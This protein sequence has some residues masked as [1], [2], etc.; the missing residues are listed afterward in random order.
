MFS[1]LSWS[2]TKKP[3]DGQE[4]GDV[5]ATRTEEEGGVVFTAEKCPPAP[6]LDMSCE[7]PFGFIW[8]PMGKQDSNAVIVDGKMPPVL[9]LN[10]LCY[11]NPHA[12]VDAKAGIWICPLCEHENVAP[13]QLLKNCPELTSKVI[14]YH[15]PVP[16]P[17]KGESEDEED[18]DD[19]GDSDE[20]RE[21]DEEGGGILVKGKDDDIEI[22]E[23]TT[24]YL[25]VDSHLNGPDALAIGSTMD[26][27]I[28]ESDRPVRI[29]L[30]VFDH[31]VKI[32]RLGVPG[33]VSADVYEA[34]DDDADESVLLERKKEIED[35]AY[36]VETDAEDGVT[37]SLD[38]CLTAIFGMPG[39]GTSTMKPPTRLEMLKKKREGRL[40]KLANSVWGGKGDAN[41]L[42]QTTPAVESPW[43][44]Q[45]S[46][47]VHPQ[48]CTSD[49][50]QAALDM[51]GVVE[52]SQGTR[53]L[54]FTNGCPNMGEGS[55]VNPQDADENRK[56][57]DVIDPDMLSKSVEYFDL[58]ANVAL[59]AGVGI[60][61]FCAGSNEL[62]LPA[63]QSLVDPSGGYVVPQLSFA[64]P[65]F[66]YNLTYLIEQTYL[67]RSK[68]EVAAE[69]DDPPEVYLDIRSDSFMDP[70]Q[71]VGPGEIMPVETDQMMDSELE[72]YM[73]GQ[74]L[75]EDNDHDT[76]NLPMEEAI[77]LSLTRIK[78]ARFD[79][80]TTLAVMCQVNDSMEDEDEAAFFQFVTRYYDK[81]GEKMV[82]RVVSFRLDVA[83]DV[84]EF[85][86]SVDDEA[87][88]VILAKSAVY[89]AV[90][91]RDETEGAKD[92]TVAGD[93]ETLEKLSYEAQLDMDA[94]I[95][96]ISG[97]FRL[98]GLEESMKK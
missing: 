53:V 75:A 72:A 23:G 89:R 90:H 61:V 9:C 77:A 8:T 82:T 51:I 6:G 46:N 28:K 32:Y 48:R 97:A 47:K 64:T 31:L 43:V 55:V 37:A 19:E 94:T 42:S 30:I 65:Q 7:L 18:E 66:E 45:R 81:E 34:L 39:D 22:F 15:Q 50:I 78:V 35:R 13:K 93:N 74:E 1:S 68:Y 27:V 83:E 14:E 60:D 38:R 95:Q 26:K 86:S 10:C 91:G 4:D 84:A 33:V 25:V 70:A 56:K 57:H 41:G 5:V 98:L 59:E 49:A 54:L 11:L 40:R 36:I 76:E 3:A 69:N 17:E 52:P 80:L 92:M 20:G 73:E 44:K 87:I 24:F 67:A 62:G 16:K 85:V 71:L 63:Y 21:N 29:A 12:E 88:S 58:M 96:R 79:P 2:P